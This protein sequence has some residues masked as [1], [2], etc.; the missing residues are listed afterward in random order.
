MRYQQDPKVL[1]MLVNTKATIRDAKSGKIKR[2][3]KY[4]NLV[5]NTG[6]ALI[7]EF[8]GNST[9]SITSMSPNYC[10]VGTSSTAVALGDTTLGV[11]TARTVV[12]SKTSSGAVAY[13]TGYFGATDVSGTL[14]EVGL[15]CNATG[16]ANSGTLFNRV[17]I[18]VTKST[19]ETLTI[20][21][22]FTISN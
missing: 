8:I 14:R 12:S 13:I 5:V 2:V 9:P 4:H 22:D 19:S 18:N 20:D 3:Y 15:F 21:I 16:T 6:L 1:K 10:A 11:E 17:I 7:A